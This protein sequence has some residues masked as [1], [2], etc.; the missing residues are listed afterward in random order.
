M[1]NPTGVARFLRR[2]TPLGIIRD[3]QIDSVTV[4][5]D[6]NLSPRSGMRH[7]DSGQDI[8]VTQEEK[9]RQL[10]EKGITLQQNPLTA[11]QFF[12]LTDLLF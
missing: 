3:V 1:M 10:T 7:V 2:K 4:I 8:E 12:K 6:S 5:T 11:D 9:L